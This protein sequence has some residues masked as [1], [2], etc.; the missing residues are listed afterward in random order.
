V[1]RSVSQ[2]IMPMQIMK[3]QLTNKSVQAS[4]TV[5]PATKAILVFLSQELNHVC[6][7]NELDARARAGAGVNVLGETDTDETSPT[8]GQF[9]YH[10]RPQLANKTPY[11]PRMPSNQATDT[12]DSNNNHSGLTFEDPITGVDKTCEIS[13]PVFWE[14][15]QCQLSSDVQPAQM[16]TEQ[17][18]P[19]GLVSRAWSLYVNFI[20]KSA[21]YRSSLMSYSEFCGYTNANYASAPR[22]GSRGTYLFI[23]I[24]ITDIDCRIGHNVQSC[25]RVVQELYN[26][27]SKHSVYSVQYCTTCRFVTPLPAGGGWV[28]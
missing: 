3:R 15:L 1:P 26:I 8:Y 20:A 7:N 14:S 12:T 4:F 18:P 24:L 28:C 6:I 10:S 23:R 9:L 13:A 27:H 17:S 25:T 22:C 2:K 21:G 16:L 19:D 11:D 5:S